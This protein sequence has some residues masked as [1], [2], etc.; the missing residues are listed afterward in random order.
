MVR[1]AQIAKKVL[2]TKKARA[3]IKAQS[4]GGTPTPRA[5]AHTVASPESANAKKERRNGEKW[6]GI[7]TA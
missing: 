3:M 1:I 6:Q 4:E 2:T 7:L 5:A